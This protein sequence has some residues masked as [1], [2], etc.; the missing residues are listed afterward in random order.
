MCRDAIN[1][2]L[3]LGDEAR[4]MNGELLGGEKGGCPASVQNPIY[5]T[6]F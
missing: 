5:Q 2:A 4:S 6:S 3:F 1:H